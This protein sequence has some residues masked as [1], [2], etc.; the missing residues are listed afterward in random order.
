MVY[1]EQNDLSGSEHQGGAGVSAGG[2]ERH[3][4]GQVYAAGQSGWTEEQHEDSP[5]A[6]PAIQTGPQ[7]EPPEEGNKQFLLFET[8]SQVY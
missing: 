4:E 2:A 6:E 7:T 1:N 8:F 3:Q 5:A